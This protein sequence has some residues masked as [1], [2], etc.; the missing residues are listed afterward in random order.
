[1]YNKVNTGKYIN[2]K[3]PISLYNK[4]LFLV[5]VIAHFQVLVWTMYG[6]ASVVDGAV[7]FSVAVEYWQLSSA[8]L[9]FPLSL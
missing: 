9:H 6:A 5:F 2:K 3:F 1:L 8:S 7:T 4:P